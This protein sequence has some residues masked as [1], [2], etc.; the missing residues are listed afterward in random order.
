[1]GQHAAE[2][3]AARFLVIV[4]SYLPGQTPIDPDEKAG[5]IPEHLETMDELNAWE[6]L[7][8]THASKWANAQVNKRELLEEGFV[9][10][11]HGRMLDETWSWAGKFR[12][13][14]KNIGVPWEQVAVSLDQLLQNA[15]WR[16]D[17]AAPDP[18]AFAV[19]FHFDLV[20]IHAFPNG[21][22]RHARLMAD[23]LVMGSGRDRFSWGAGAVLTGDTDARKKYLEAIYAANK[24]Q[25]TALLEFARS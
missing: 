4:Y 6:Q 9:R 13:S 3:L 20:S 14:D 18:D 21:N 25:S 19:Q 17:N 10:E 15:R 16:R 12:K 22:G 8:I 1:M 7:N 2:W 5:L 11:L 23:L 24:N